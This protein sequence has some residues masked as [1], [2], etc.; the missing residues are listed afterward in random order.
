MP[1]LKS[2]CAA[3]AASDSALLTPFIAVAITDG[4]SERAALAA[5]A[6][7]RWLARNAAGVKAICPRTEKAASAWMGLVSCLP[8]LE[9]V[10]LR[11]AGRLAA[12]KLS[13][14]LEALAWCPRLEELALFVSLAKVEGNSIAQPSPEVPSFANLRNL[15]TLKLVFWGKGPPTLA[16][17]VDALVSLARLAVLVVKFIRTPAVLVPAALAR[18]QG[19][20]V[21]KLCD[22]RP[23]VLEMGCLNLPSLVRL[24]FH[25][26]H[27]ADTQVLLGITALQSLTHIEISDSVGPRFFDPQLA[28][29]PRLQKILWR[30]TTPCCGGTYRV[31][32]NVGSL[33]SSLVYL[34]FRGHGLTLF[35]LALMQLVA[36][37]YLNASSN[38]FAELPAG[39]TALSRLTELKLG[40]ATPKEDQVQVHAKRPLDV[41]ALGDL[42]GFP[43]LCKLTFECCEV[44]VCTSMPGA[45]HHANLMRLIFCM[46]HPAPQCALMVLQLGRALKDLGRGRV[47]EVLNDSE[48]CNTV[49]H[50]LLLAKG[51]PP[52]DQFKAALA[53]CGL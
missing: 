18:L 10:T 23:C 36:L 47:L 51:P 5:C 27:F 12:E 34:S 3:A 28:R 11:L 14:L 7:R 16:A 17:V 24:Q 46:A 33:C 38:E 53:A 25:R 52:F 44:L 43:A 20:E 2:L 42:S 15:K 30:T 49:D 22:V 35:P 50:G 31:P 41:R 8:A 1:C 19:L 6:A 45:A 26:C 4:Q 40:R 29:L 9:R 13:C 21:L 39:I 48:E 32:A 37:E